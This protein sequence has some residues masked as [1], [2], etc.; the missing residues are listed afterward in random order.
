[1]HLPPGVAAMLPTVT[2]CQ[3][4]PRDSNGRVGPESLI[5][6]SSASSGLGAD[7]YTLGGQVF[8]TTGYGG[9]PFG[10]LVVTPAVAGPFN[11]GNVDRA[12]KDQRRP[13]HSGR[14]RSRADT[15]P[16]LIKGVPVQLKQINVTV[17]RPNF[18][19]N[20]TNCSP[21]AIEGTLTGAQGASAPVSSPFQVANCQGLPFKPKL[22]ASTKGQ[23]SKADG[24]SFDVKVRIGKGLGQ[25]N[26]AKVRLQLPKALPATAD[27]ASESVYRRGVQRQ[28]GV[29]S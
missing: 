27:D 7:P 15:F 1:M 26:I 14:E 2:P 18:E 4:P 22:T 16:T 24:A 17:D 28:S 13:Q 6:H 11:L 25:A 20:P 21:M 29:V 9:A 12:L 19:F 5:G 23:A 3:E 10:I 8:L